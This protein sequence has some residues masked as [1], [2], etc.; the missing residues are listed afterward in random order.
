VLNAKFDSFSPRVS[1]DWKYAPDS[2]LYALFSRG[3][4]PGGFNAALVTSSPAAIAALQAVVPSAGL[5]FEEEQLDNYE[6]GIKSTWLEGRAHTTLTVYKGEWK[7]GQVGNAIPVT[8][9]GTSNLFN[10]V[11]NNGVADLQGVEF[12][13]SLQATQ[14]LRLSAT[15]GYNDT[16]IQSYGIGPGGVAGNCGECNLVYG[17]FAGVI[18]RELPTVPKLTWSAAADYSAPVNGSISW[19]GRADYQHQ[20]KKYSDFAGATFVGDRQNVNARIGLRGDKWTAEIFGTNLTD[21]D[22]FL[23]AYNGVDVLTFLLPPNKNEVRFAPPIPRSF[24]IRATYEF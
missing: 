22:T 6:V 13:G 9:A 20:G 24:G 23:S 10:I 12:E 3:Y 1:I 18:G 17:S 19:Y 21:D 5:T 15:L 4:R 7:N 14:G 16:E 8:V 2:L 11:I